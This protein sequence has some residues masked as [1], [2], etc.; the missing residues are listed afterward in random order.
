MKTLTIAQLEKA[1]VAMD[2]IWTEGNTLWFLGSVSGEKARL[3]KVA[4]G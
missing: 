3:F 2:Y 4:L 1:H